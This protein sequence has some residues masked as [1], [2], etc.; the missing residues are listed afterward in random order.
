[1]RERIVFISTLLFCLIFIVA[2]M[3]KVPPS[4]DEFLPYHQI[5]CI[6]YPNAAENIFRESCSVYNLNIFGASLPLRAYSYTGF[7][8][9]LIYLPFF[10]LWK[11]YLSARLLKLLAFL[12][13]AFLVKK[14]SRLNG[15]MTCSIVLLCLPLAFQYIVDLGPFAFQGTIA[16]AAAY[17]IAR[18]KSYWG[19]ALA[20]A[21]LF[22]G[23]DQKPIFSVLL[24]PIALLAVA[25]IYENK[26]V[27][28]REKVKRVG[29]IFAAVFSMLLP[30]S[31]L[32][33]SKNNSGISYFKELASHPA[34]GIFNFS[35]QYEQFGAISPFLGSFEKFGHLVFDTHNISPWP[36]AVVWIIY[37]LLIL[38]AI[39]K[40]FTDKDPSVQNSFW[41]FL[42]SL[43]GFLFAIWGVSRMQ[44]SGNAH[45]PIIAFPFLILSI[46]YALGFLVKRKYSLAAIVA[47]VLAALNIFM[48]YDLLSSPI[49]SQ[50]DW[51]RLKI[52][53][54]FNNPKSSKRYL[55]VAAD[56]GMYY[57]M[58]LYG[59]KNQTVVFVEP[60]NS[61]EQ[62]E[63]IDK[64]A[65]RKN[66][67]PVYITREAYGG[68]VEFV[69]KYHTLRKMS[70][71]GGNDS[72]VW[73]V[74]ATIN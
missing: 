32:F 68:S 50:H 19:G 16:L 22:I 10:L 9:S 49:Q 27:F 67:T 69:K 35:R 51:S 57:L 38:F 25:L 11:S 63:A 36:T 58:S 24:L 26:K 56:W 1:V 66:L 44:E 41:P 62:V 43:F 60:I 4:M 47:I 17:L 53:N 18:S 52:M 14:I 13:L 15:W 54:E 64:I 30:L 7:T 34:I 72:S 33:L 39:H 71:S 42:A 21:L 65:K 55:Y 8:P 37:A 28:I 74:Y 61:K 3:V 6:Y 70:Y 48:G 31:L 12:L 20:G 59:Q 40:K 29:V 2:L 45:H 23:V 73:Q 46:A 5:A